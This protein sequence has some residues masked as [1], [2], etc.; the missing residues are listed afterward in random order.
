[1]NAIFTFTLRPITTQSVNFSGSH[2][3]QRPGVKTWSTSRSSLTLRGKHTVHRLIVSLALFFT[4]QIA[5][6]NDWPQFLSPNRNST[7]AEK[8]ISRKWPESGPEVV[9]KVPVGRGFVGPAI[10]DGRVFLLDRNDNVGET[11]R[12][13]SLVDGSVL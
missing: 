4:P 11:L 1:M 8:G 10:H 6:A 5:F 3:A 12:C 7:S 2:A 9:W 13:M